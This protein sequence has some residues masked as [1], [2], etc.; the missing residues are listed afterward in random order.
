M[1]STVKSAVTWILL[2]FTFT[3]CVSETLLVGSERGIKILEAVTSLPITIHQLLPYVLATSVDFRYKN[4]DIYFISNNQILYSYYSEYT[5]SHAEPIPI[6]STGQRLV[7][8]AVDWRDF[9][10]YYTTDNGGASSTIYEAALLGATVAPFLEIMGASITDLAL[11][12]YDRRFFYINDDG[13][14]MSSLHEKRSFSDHFKYH[15]STITHNITAVS[16]VSVD[17]HNKHVYVVGYDENHHQWHLVSTDYLNSY[18]TLLFNGGELAQPFALGVFDGVVVWGS[19]THG[20]YIVYSCK[21]TP[22][23]D[24]DQLEI[25]YRSEEV[26]HDIKFFNSH[27]QTPDPDTAC[28]ELNC[29]HNCT[30]LSQYTVECTCPAGLTI[31]GE[32]NLCIED[33]VTLLKFRTI[34]SQLQALVMEMID[35]VLQWLSSPSFYLTLLILLVSIAALILLFCCLCVLTCLRTEQRSLRKSESYDLSE[36]RQAAGDTIV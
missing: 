6:I 5:D 15:F 1:V 19:K 16:K 3:Y 29:S 10:L 31:G 27:T 35:Y 17:H 9:K 8:L 23:C 25:V 30:I 12:V 26:I 11:D 21:L 13:L 33:K 14:Y 34:G 18:S 22:A 7:D 24:I 28:A 36:T 32:G 2:C 20:E 4:R